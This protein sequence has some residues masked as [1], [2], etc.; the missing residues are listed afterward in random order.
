[1]AVFRQVYVSFWQDTKV[2]EE[3]TPEDRYFYL[4]TLTNPYTKQIGIYQITKK[5]MA[6]ELGY[7]RESVDSLVDRFIYHHKL[8]R[9]NDE[10]RELAIKNWGKYNFNKGGKPVM[11][12]VVSELRQVKDIELVKYVA[13]NITNTTIKKIYEA[14]IDY[15]NDTSANRAQFVYNMLPNCGEEKELNKNNYNNKNNKPTFNNFKG[16]EYTPEQIK[17]MTENMLKK[18]RGEL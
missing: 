16:R 2:L 7:S 14:F 17:K 4:Y 6:F 9:Y 18:S 11:D 13:A 1:M 3:M 12:C 10:T 8:M 15:C 5:T